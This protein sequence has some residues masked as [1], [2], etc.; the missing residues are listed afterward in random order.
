MIASTCVS[1]GCGDGFVREGMEE[2]DDGEGNSDSAARAA[3]P[4]CGRAAAMVLNTGRAAT[5]ATRSTLTRAAT[6]A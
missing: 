2:C 1:A 6:T 3:R 5:T 4:A